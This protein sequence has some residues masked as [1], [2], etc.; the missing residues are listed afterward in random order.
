MMDEQGK[1]YS[2]SLVP[3]KP[4]NKV[5]PATAEEV[6]G[7]GL[8]K[9]NSHERTTH[10]T[11]GR[12]SVS[13]ALARVRQAALREKQQQ[14]TALLRHV[15]T[16][17]LLRESYLALKREAAA[18]IDGEMWRHY[19]ERLEEH[20]Q[21]LSARVKRGAYRAQPVRR[22]Y[23]PKTDGR[24]RPIGIST[25]GDKIVQRAT[26]EVLHAIYETAFL[27][28]S[29]GFRPGSICHPYPSVRFVG[30]IYGRNRMR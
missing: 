4:S 6:E 8:A 1:S 15:Y 3:K 2:S 17:E 29:Y 25:V 21:D 22:V 18:G 16:V 13:N 9:E 30:I 19:G 7:R 26:A 5:A 12:E 10:R 24:Q 28:F 23:V 11:Q 14:F 27:G 20:L